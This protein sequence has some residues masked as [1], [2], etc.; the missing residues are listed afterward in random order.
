MSM[1]AASG[2]TH[3]INRC[4]RSQA[5]TSV[6]EVRESPLANSVTVVA[7]TNELIGQHGND[8]FRSAVE[9]WWNTFTQRCNL[10]NAQLP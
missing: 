5:A 10:R 1:C 3:P 9:L 4:A 6:A 2:S 8:T 7:L